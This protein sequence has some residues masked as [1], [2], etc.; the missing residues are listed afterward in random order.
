MSKKPL[1]TAEDC[2]TWMKL[3]DIKRSALKFQKKKKI[4]KKINGT[5]LNKL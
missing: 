3:R 2:M 5:D 1:I 4:K